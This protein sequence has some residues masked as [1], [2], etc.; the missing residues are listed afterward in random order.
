MATDTL[1]HDEGH[2]AHAHAHHI[3][4]LSTY[5]NVYLA[6]VVLTVVTVGVSY[7]GL[8]PKPSL[9]VAMFVALI[10]ASLVC[11][12]FMH[13]KYD[14]KFNVFVF[15]SA[16]WFGG[17]FFLFTFIDLTSRGDILKI[18]DNEELREDRIESTQR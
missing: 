1:R 18:Q 12:W 2:D 8:P 15:L 5:I 7:L 11:A 13:L 17:A 3:S 14:T 6:L 9:F 10:K 4:P 16:V